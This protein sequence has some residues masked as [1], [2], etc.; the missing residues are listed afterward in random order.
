MDKKYSEQYMKLYKIIQNESIPLKGNP[1]IDIISN[2]REVDSDI[3]SGCLFILSILC[4]I[5][6]VICIFTPWKKGIWIFLAVAV[7]LFVS[8]FLNIGISSQLERKVQREEE[9][10][11]ADRI[12]LEQ[13]RSCHYAVAGYFYY[14]AYKNKSKLAKERLDKLLETPELL[15][16]FNENGLALTDEMREKDRMVGLSWLYIDEYKKY[17][18]KYYG[19]KIK[20]PENFKLFY[21]SNEMMFDN[22]IKEYDNPRY[23][24]K[25]SEDDLYSLV[26]EHHS[27]WCLGITES[28]ELF[29]KYY[30]DEEVKDGCKSEKKEIAEFYANNASVLLNFGKSADLFFEIMNAVE[31]ITDS[32]KAGKELSKNEND[33]SEKT[34]RL[35]SMLMKLPPK[36]EEV[37]KELQGNEY[38][39][40]EVT[41]VACRFAENCFCECRDFE[42]D[43]DRKP[44][45]EE[46]H[47]SYIYT[48]CEMLLKYGLDPNLVLGDKNGETNIIYEL[49]YVDNMYKG[50]ETIRLM[51]ENGGSTQTEIDNE[52]IFSMIDFDVAFDVV[53]LDNKDLYDKEFR[54]WLLMIGYGAVNNTGRCPLDIVDGYDIENFKEFEKFSYKI[55]FS[56]KDWTMHIFDNEINKEV[57]KL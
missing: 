15:G 50:A 29:E 33:T 19:D 26:R 4:I 17:V 35:L 38:T 3:I 7:F 56:E 18:T 43:N 23:I 31:N 53:E 52:S 5:A 28:R 47:S 20:Y 30:L 8:I 14:S 41:L 36:L 49:R 39:S 57:A 9:L 45:E 22:Q 42:L 51:L 24:K 12:F 40:E 34:E 44:E 13:K 6:S 1:I 46:V 21:K 27:N 2:M 11:K 16:Y 10:K 54:I 25:A 48:I 55:E 37:E 32:K